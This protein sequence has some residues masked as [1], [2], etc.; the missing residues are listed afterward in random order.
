MQELEPREQIAY[1]GRMLF[2][3]R[4]TDICGGNISLRVED[5][6]FITPKY[7]GARQHWDIDP[8]SI[9]VGDVNSDTIVNHQDFSREGKAHLDIYRTFPEAAAIL[10]AHPFHV[11]PFCASGKPIHPVLEGAEALGTINLIPYAPSHTQELADNLVKGLMEKRE[12]I[13][14]E[15][16]AVL[17][18]R[19]GLL[20]I[21][22]DL[23]KCLEAVEKIDWNAWCILALPTSP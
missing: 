4:L 14:S 23:F 22:N 16:A 10:H 12:L 20:V 6:I 15:A 13:R 5:K 21:S 17:M 3:R 9:L 2:K 7:S 8:A 18:P 1:V 11:L 19:H